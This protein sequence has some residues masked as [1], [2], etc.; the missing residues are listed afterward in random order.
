[1]NDQDNEFL[2][3]MAQAMEMYF[4]FTE[5][6]HEIPNIQIHAIPIEEIDRENNQ[7][8]NVPTPNEVVEEDSEEQQNKE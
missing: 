3:Q 2:Q 8:D 6:G 5:R 7:I 4:N 1:M